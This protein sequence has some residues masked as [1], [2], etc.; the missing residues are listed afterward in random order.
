[1]KKQQFK[2]AKLTIAVTNITEMVS[3]YE[4]VFNCNFKKNNFQG[5]TLYSSEIAGIPI[6]LC[7]NV[8]ANVVAEQN[9]QQFDFVVTDLNQ[10]ISKVKAYNGI[11]RG[12]IE[13]LQEGKAVTVV[14]PDG[15]TIVFIE[16]DH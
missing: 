3:F 5:Y 10:I 9:R 4:N 1:M 16:K 11:V 8:L 2:I 6:Q 13:S 15:N 12:E 7:P 14:D